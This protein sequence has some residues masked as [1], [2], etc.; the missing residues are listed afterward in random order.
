VSANL[1]NPSVLHRRILA[2]LAAGLGGLLLNCFSIDVFGGA[3][4]SFGGILSLAVALQLGPVYG[5]IAS[6]ITELPSFFRIHDGYGIVF[7]HALEAL[8]IGWSGR[9]RI[10]PIVADAAYWCVVGAPVVFAANHPGQTAPLWAIVIK[11]LL[12]G[13]L[14]VT[15]ADL[16]TGWPRVARLFSNVPQSYPLRTHLSRGFL[17]ATAVPFLTLNVAIDWIHGARL[18]REAGAHVHEAL[19]RVVADTN[20]FVDKHQS[21]LIALKQILERQP[22]LDETNLQ[23]WIEHYHEV[24]PAFRIL[25]SINVAGKVTASSPDLTPT[26]RS[27]RGTDISDRQYFRETLASLRPY[28]SDVFISRELGTDPIVSLTAPVLAPDGSLRAILYGSLRCSR[29][30]DLGAS[31]SSLGNSELVILDQQNR[32]IFASAGAPFKPMQALSGGSLLEG[33]QRSRDGFF[34]ENRPRPNAV[35]EPRLASLG[36]TDAGWTVLISQPLAIV[37]AESLDYY[38][39]TACWVLIGLLISTLGARWLSS[40]LTRPVEGLVERVG[41]CVM[42]G[43]EPPPTPLSENAP[44]ELVKLVRDFD[45]M[46]RRLNDSYRQLQSALGDRERLNHELAGVLEHLEGKVKERTAELAEAKERAEE[47]SRLK[48]EFLANMSHE[49]RTPMNGLMGMMDV[50][51]ET[52]LD[53]DQRDYLETARTSADTLLHLLNEILDFSKIEA[54]KLDLSPSPFCVPVLVEEAAR[55]LDIVARQK[56]LELRREAEPGVPLVV[57]ADPTRLKQVMLNLLNNAVKFTAWGFVELRASVVAIEGR[58]A[59][60]HFSV[61][62]SGIGLSEAQRKVIFDAFRQADGSTTRRYGGTGLGLSISKRLVEMMGGEIWVDSAPGEGSTFH[63][64]IRAG[65]QPDRQ[66]AREPV[67]ELIR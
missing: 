37:L 55:A 24:Y 21:G 35:A 41:Q 34:R 62:D 45:Q 50:V 53:T 6:L 38:L 13:L 19:V 47:G 8:V 4:M 56:G 16:L 12:N 54:G 44:L 23:A 61:A 36:R 46:G 5:V 3:R 64:T 31:L 60:L 66:P 57:V 14:D 2:A 42:G 17:L 18:Q 1:A 52:S 9:R 7:T 20:N 22:D 65:L 32:V 26:G 49:I 63:F 40:R 11:N 28:V 59:V 39:I 58:E 10:L 27:L 33:S 15:L 67:A 30:T 51:L 48:S 25:A 43:P 29:F